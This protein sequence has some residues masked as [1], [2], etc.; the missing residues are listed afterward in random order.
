M[1]VTEKQAQELFRFL[2]PIQVIQ[3]NQAAEPVCFKAGETVYRL[4][5][6]ATYMYVVISGKIALLAPG[7]K[8]A[9]VLV[10]ELGEG[11]LFGVCVCVGVDSYTVTA[12]CVEEAWLLR[13]KTDV[14][15][16][17]MEDDFE[18]G[19]ALQKQIAKIYFRRYANTTRQLSA[20][21]SHI[22][23]RHV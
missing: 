3:L 20:I 14:L 11:K 16:K 10:N 5:E 8:A 2:P 23:M 19:Y 7:D 22:P 1:E 4:G 12:Q 9:N 21:V 15:K 6:K 13:I 18:V 17:L